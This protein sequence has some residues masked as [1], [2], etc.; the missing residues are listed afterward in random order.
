MVLVVLG[1]VWSHLCFFVGWL[2]VFGIRS[3]F[4]TVDVG[5]PVIIQSISDKCSIVS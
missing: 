4:V 3:L 5:A 1:G 2:M